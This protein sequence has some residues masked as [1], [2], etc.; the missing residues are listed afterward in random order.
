MN[1]L[2]IKVSIGA[3]LT[4]LRTARD[5]SQKQI[6]Q[7]FNLSTPSMV[8]KYESGSIQMPIDLIIGIPKKYNVRLEWWLYGEGGIDDNVSQANTQLQIAIVSVNDYGEQVETGFL[9]VLKENIEPYSQGE[10]RAVQILDDAMSPELTSGDYV[11]YARGVVSS[12]GLYVI[13]CDTRIEVRRIQFKY[14][15]TYTILPSNPKYEKQVVD[16]DAESF[17][18]A[19]RVIGWNHHY[20]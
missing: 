6:A 17:L 13:Q 14:D 4:Q 11:L 18:I 7:D 12:D 5:I 20:S 8:S 19:G 1:K 16:R 9:P 10:I 15:K 2:N 3:R